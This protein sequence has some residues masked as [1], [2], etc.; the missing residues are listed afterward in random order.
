MDKISPRS[1]YELI[2]GKSEFSLVDLR[3]DGVFGE[4]HLLFA[5][6][7][8]LSHME[9]LVGN[10]I[11]N[12]HV[13]II[14]CGKGNDE[15]L[16]DRGA[17]R[18]KT[19]G[20]KNISILSGGVDAWEQ[21]GFELFSGI[22]VPSKA[23][24][25]FIETNNKT[26]HVSAEK[27]EQMIKLEEKLVILDSRPFSEY[28]LMS[29]PGGINVP[30]AELSYR[31]AD[32]SLGLDTTIVVNCAGRTRSI[33]GAQS[34]I[35]AGVLNKV[36]ALENG[37][38][39]WHLAG[40]DLE[41]GSSIR[42]P[43][44]SECGHKVAK[45]RAKTLIKK[46]KIEKIDGIAVNKMM[47][48]FRRTTYLLDVRDPVE[49][50]AGHI[51]GS[52]SSPG[53][54]LIQ[55]TDQYI[56]VRSS[57]LILIDNDDIRAAMTASWLKQ[58]GWSEVFVFQGGISAAGKLHSGPYEPKILG[59]DNEDISFI[60][61]IEFDDLM[62]D[63]G[64]KVIDFASSSIYCDNGHIPGAYF[65][66]RANLSNSLKKIG[67]ANIFI[68]TSPDGKLAEMAAHDDALLG[69]NVKVLKGGTSSWVAGGLS[70][71]KGFTRMA[72]KANDVWYR[73]YDFKDGAEDA[74]KQYLSWE[75]ELINQI[76]RD[77][78]TNFQGI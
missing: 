22:N 29:I 40:K 25:E 61:L 10:L 67:N 77:G 39:G 72:D 4:R 58:M 1:L 56:A 17:L 62:E 70:L 57:R 36:V 49:F 19:F 35:N 47:N 5:V 31:V 50:K 41:Y 8:P 45:C 37:I 21:E 73:P 46:F 32:L 66:I 12:R 69:L 26:P 18:L 71:E 9:F 48:D 51:P 13:P 42:F 54:Q 63:E 15:D 43:E 53:G 33:I 30:G 78:T 7:I 14:L 74:M 65:A 59:N 38:M 24:G 20:Y 2:K 55:A 52:I 3:E 27:L 68:L 16:I 6:N 60:E 34:L 11:P 75:I 64:I 76:R 28:E 23:F 44:I